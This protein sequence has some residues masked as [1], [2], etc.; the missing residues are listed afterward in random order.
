MANTLEAGTIL[1]EA[2]TLVPEC[3]RLEG[4]P[5]SNGWRSVAN[6]N[7]RELDRN[8]NQAGWI[9]FYIA[10]EIRATV[11]GFDKQ[12]ALHRALKR[13]ITRVK[14]QNCNGLH[15]K[16][17]TSGSFLNVTCVRISAHSRHIQEGQS[18]W[19]AESGRPELVG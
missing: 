16:Q 9:F 8:I 17:V 7:P 13:I 6:V 5:D 1:I 12:K 11:F 2:G 18:L 14:T 19:S 15:I 10:E 3:L 4:E